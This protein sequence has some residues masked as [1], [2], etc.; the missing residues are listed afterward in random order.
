M[1]A[2]TGNGVCGAA[3][4]RRGDAVNE[5][6]GKDVDAYGDVGNIPQAPNGA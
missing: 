5:A 3:G 6:R 1:K 2:G 4:G